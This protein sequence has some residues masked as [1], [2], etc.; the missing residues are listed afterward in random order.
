MQFWGITEDGRKIAYLRS[1]VSHVYQVD[2]TSSRFTSLPT[3]LLYEVLN[4]LKV[5]RKQNS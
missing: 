2:V 5:K 3:N 1:N 4:G